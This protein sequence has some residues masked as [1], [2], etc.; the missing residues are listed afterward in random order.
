MEE[1]TPR[2]VAC[3]WWNARR[4][5]VSAFC[6]SCRAPFFA[7]ERRHSPSCAGSFEMRLVNA[8][9]HQRRCGLE[10]TRVDLWK[11]EIGFGSVGSLKLNPN[12]GGVVD[13]QIALGQ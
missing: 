11:A 13:R 3:T 1:A 7:T 2:F 4:L 8:R 6:H 5:V 12:C 9:K 10:N